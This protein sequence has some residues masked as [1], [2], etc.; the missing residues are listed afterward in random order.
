MASLIILALALFA[1]AASATELRIVGGETTSVNEYPSIAQV[2]F[3]GTASGIWSQSCGANILT[4]R[5]VLSAAQCFSGIFYDPKNRRIRAGTSYRNTGGQLAYVQYAFNHPS[6][7]QNDM[8]ADITV[9]LL[10]EPFVYNPNIQQVTIVPQGYEIPA[11]VSSVLVGWGAT[12]IGGLQSTELQAAVVRTIPRDE[13]LEIYKNLTLARNVTENM[14]CTQ[15]FDDDTR[16]ACQGDFGG[17][18]YFS[19]ILVGIL[20]WGQGCGDYPTV[21]TAVSSYTDWIVSVAV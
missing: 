7:G 11:N 1:G 21:S 15:S 3:L 13:C 20:S 6:Y 2:D 12:Q 8:D 9:V 19:D 17:P 18:V 16:D 14:I 4:S 5:Y 10:K